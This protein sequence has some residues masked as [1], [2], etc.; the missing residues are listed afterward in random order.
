MSESVGEDVRVVLEE[1]EDLFLKSGGREGKKGRKGI[2]RALVL[3]VVAVAVE[4]GIV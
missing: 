4:I 2:C 1:A 3:R